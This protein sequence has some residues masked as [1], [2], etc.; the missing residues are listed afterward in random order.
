MP[1]A[2]TS[3][4]LQE[5]LNLGICRFNATNTALVLPDGSQ[6]PLAQVPSRAVV[7]NNAADY[8]FPADA[9]YVGF[10]GT[11]KAALALTFPAGSALING[12]HIAIYTAA[13]T[14]TSVSFTS[15]GATFVGAPA[16]LAAGSVT[17][18]VYNHA[19]TQW[20][21]T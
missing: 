14:A 19:T 11:Q 5:L 8:V 15:A 20:L 17:R 10:T 13:A 2:S 7:N 12:R 9:S 21:L 4:L 18:F 3:P 6:Y 16:T 1:Y